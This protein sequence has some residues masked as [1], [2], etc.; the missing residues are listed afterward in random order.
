MVLNSLSIFFYLKCISSRKKKMISFSVT[1]VDPEMSPGRKIWSVRIP[2]LLF[3]S[4]GQT[5]RWP[6]VKLTEAIQCLSYC[7]DKSNGHKQFHCLGVL[8]VKD[9]LVFPSFLKSFA[10]GF[11]QPWN[12]KCCTFKSVSS[13]SRFRCWPICFLPVWTL[14]ITLSLSDEPGKSLLLIMLH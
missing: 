7:Y 13:H 9:S 2:V 11:L 1:S 6:H 14:E 5:L 3:A 4:T 8:D 10:W 12:Q